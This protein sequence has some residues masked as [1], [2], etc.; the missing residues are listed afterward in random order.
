M[1]FARNVRGVYTMG[2]LTQS[3]RLRECPHAPIVSGCKL[4]RL[5]VDHAINR[6]KRTVTYTLV[7]LWWEDVQYVKFYFTYDCVLRDLSVVLLHIRRNWQDPQR[8]RTAWD[9][10]L[11]RDLNSQ[12]IIVWISRCKLLSG[13]RPRLSTRGYF[14]FCFYSLV[15]VR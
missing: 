12:A 3:I 4:I 7:V 5:H 11:G 8:C 2:C 10:K 15:T 9:L 6:I 14:F 13:Q 1:G